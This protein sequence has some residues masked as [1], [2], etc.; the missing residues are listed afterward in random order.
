MYAQPRRAKRLHFEV[1]PKTVDEYYQHRA[2]ITEQD[3][4][5]RLENPAWHIHA[6]VPEAGGLPVSFTLLLNLASVCLADTPGA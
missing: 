6:G 4:A 2:K 1:I 3:E 5:A